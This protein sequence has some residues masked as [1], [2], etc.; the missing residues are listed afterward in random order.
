MTPARIYKIQKGQI[1]I[2]NITRGQYAVLCFIHWS[3]FISCLA[4]LPPLLF[5]TNQQYI[6][7]WYTTNH[8]IL[9]LESPTTPHGPVPC[10]GL[11]HGQLY[12]M[13]IC[14]GYFERCICRQFS[15]ISCWIPH[16]SP[17]HAWVC[18]RLSHVS[19]TSSSTAQYTV[20]I[21]SILSYALPIFLRLVG[22]PSCM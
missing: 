8:V 10:V 14:Q 7:S 12:K 22:A 20:S 11:N 5:T 17:Q 21:Q 4:R 6:F 1:R 3:A 13:F 18:T 9:R 2:C 16:P 15:A 19:S